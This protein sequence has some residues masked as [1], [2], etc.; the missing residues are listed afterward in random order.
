MG[1]LGKLIRWT[2][3]KAR[4]DEKTH[5]KSDPEAKKSKG[6]AKLMTYIGR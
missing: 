2:D 6:I 3:S 1:L 4:K 5:I